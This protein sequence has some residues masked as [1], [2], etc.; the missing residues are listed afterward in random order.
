MNISEKN[1]Q[2]LL[3]GGIIGGALLLIMGYFY[4]M[5]VGPEVATTEA[6]VVKI[7]TENRRNNEQLRTFRNFLEDEEQRRIVEDQFERVAARLPSGQDPVDVFELLR[8]Y[9]EGTD[10]QFTNLETGTS[11]NRGRFTEYPFSMKGSARYHEFGQLVNLIEC[12]P[13]RLMR[14]NDIKLTNNPNRPSIHPM[15]LSLSTFTFNP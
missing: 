6:E 8:G 5:V 12:D 13:K 7:E 15:E 10:V 2:I 3:A 4:F 14:I 9:F 1:K 11:V